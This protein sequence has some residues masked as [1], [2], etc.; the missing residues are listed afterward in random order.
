MDAVYLQ[1]RGIG[2]AMKAGK[3]AIFGAMAAL[4]YREQEDMGAWTA[5]QVLM[6][7]K[8]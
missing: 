1:N 2:R 4:E 7:I 5:E 8:A 3:E 6:P